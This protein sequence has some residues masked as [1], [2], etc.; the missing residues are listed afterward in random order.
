V[1]IEFKKS[2]AKDLK[3]KSDNR[4]LMDKATV[5]FAGHMD[6]TWKLV[7]TARTILA[8]VATTSA[9]N[10]ISKNWNRFGTI[11]MRT[12]WCSDI[13]DVIHRYRQCGNLQFGFAQVKCQACGHEYLLPFSCKRLQFCLSCQDHLPKRIPPY[14]ICL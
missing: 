3:K 2:F 5:K 10:L 9:L 11:D 1:R 6:V 8:S 7:F 12:A 13:K 14:L 4:K